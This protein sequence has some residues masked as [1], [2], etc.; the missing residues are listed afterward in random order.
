MKL[1]I[2]NLIPSLKPTIIGRIFLNGIIGQMDL[3]LKILNI[4]F[5]SW[6]SDVAFLKPISLHN[7][8]N[9]RHQNKVSNIEFSL[10]VQKRSINV[11]L[12]YECLLRAVIVGVFWFNYGVQLINFIDNCD[13]IASI[14]ELS[15][16]DDP[17]ISRLYFALSCVLYLL[18]NLFHVSLPLFVVCDKFF[19]LRIFHAFLYMEC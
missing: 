16:L 13:T 5:I 8:M 9:M 2:R 4:K 11:E 1:L 15:R 18:F 14:C 7:S 6:C 10:L 3:S 19:V 17:N 12:N